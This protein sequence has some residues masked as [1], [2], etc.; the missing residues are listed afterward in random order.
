MGSDGVTVRTSTEQVDQLL[1]DILAPHLVEDSPPTAP[2]T[3]SLRIVE[4]SDAAPGTRPIHQ[5]YRNGCLEVRARTPLRALRGLLTHLG[6]TA[7]SGSDHLIEVR[8]LVLIHDGGALIAPAAA[9]RE[10][11]RTERRLWDMG[12]ASVDTPAA[13]LDRGTGRLVVP[14]PFRPIDD[15]TGRT[16]DGLAPSA[17]AEPAVGPGSYP[18]VGWILGGDAPR[19]RAE[20]TARIIAQLIGPAGRGPAL[21]VIA[22]V[23]ADAHVTTFEGLRS[24]P[25]RVSSMLPADLTIDEVLA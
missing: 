25:E 1:R 19:S 3:Y 15:Q 11:Q 22:R 2:A 24:L 4:P 14:R 16:V 5:L 6:H 13:L 20:A 10:L 23:M 21:P 12:V 7:A 8:G 9:R 18:V 17:P